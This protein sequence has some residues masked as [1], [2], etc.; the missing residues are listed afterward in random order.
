MKIDKRLKKVVEKY[1]LESLTPQGEIDAKKVRK[2]VDDLKIYSTPVSIAALSEYVKRLKV[3][4]EKYTLRIKSAVSLSP[5]QISQVTKVMKSKHKISS[6][7]TEV[8]ESLLGGI[9][10]RLGDLVYD[11]SLGQKIADLKGVI[12]G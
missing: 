6:V 7:E 1:A 10:I 8:D 3:E 11:D 12:R 9:R 4:A 2:V 5:T